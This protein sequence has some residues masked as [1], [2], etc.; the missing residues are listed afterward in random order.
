MRRLMQVSRANPR[1]PTGNPL[2][3]KVATQNKTLASEARE[4]DS[5]NYAWA[6]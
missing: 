3:E 4:R 2:S 5:L 1:I 6:V